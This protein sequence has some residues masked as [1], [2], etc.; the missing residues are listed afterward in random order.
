MTRHENRPR[1]PTGRTIAERKTARPT[2]PASDDL[3]AEA[4]QTEAGTGA[5][6]GQTGRQRIAK[7]MARVGLCSRRDAEAWIVDGRVT[8]NG[9]IL[10]SP[11]QDV[12]PSD[13]I[14][15][16]GMP[17]PDA[18]KT[19]L[20][21]F[22]K[23][24]GLV[25]SDHD[26]E[27]RQT[28]TDYLR[29]TWP[30]GPRVVTVGR[31]DIN[32]EGLLLLTN[33][34]GLARVLELPSTGWIRRYRVRA[35]GETDQA[36]LDRLHDGVTIEGIDYA[37]I[38]AKLDRTQGANSWLTMGLR[39]GKN[40]EIKRVLE[41]IGLE[42]NRLIRLS[43]G[44]F[45]LLD[46]PEGKV[47]EV[48]TRV[49]RD[50]L[51]ASLAAAGG[52]DLPEEPAA[53]PAFRAETRIVSRANRPG[54]K[55]ARPDAKRGKTAAPSAGRVRDDD[56]RPTRHATGAP[57][58]REEP[59]RRERPV[60]GTRKHVS[61]LRAEERDDLRKGPRK[62]IERTDTKDRKDRTVTVE[63]L[64]TA[65]PEAPP[66]RGAARTTS[67][68]AAPD[69]RLERPVRDHSKP[70]FAREASQDRDRAP[71][72][73]RASPSA[74][75]KRVRVARS[76]GSDAADIRAARPHQTRP[77]HQARGERVVA[78]GPTGGKARS[79]RPRPEANAAEA[80]RRS[81][82]ERTHQAP[83]DKSRGDSSDRVRADR[84][85]ARSKDK[86][87]PF[88]GPSQASG[89][90]GDA[91][92]RP[93]KPRDATARAEKPRGEKTRNVGGERRVGERNA[94][95]RDARKSGGQRGASG[96]AGEKPRDPTRPPRGPAK[97]PRTA[98]PRP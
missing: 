40:R 17:L 14:L 11:A 29:E 50:Q 54:T 96:R 51:G 25:T 84:L 24:R 10:T 28:V 81:R 93:S 68:D 19:R 34:G 4:G 5:T 33:D 74:Q 98:K 78:R 92:P 26:P 88:A 32:T 57:T 41:H 13:E 82:D 85:S 64:V 69:R 44:P 21:L 73:D 15:V 71:P 66:R 79:V 61:F 77:E 72:R 89:R 49:L 76:G 27:G 45:Q 22:H 62:R 43:F 39:E 56:R 37:G 18:E 86:R 36:V 53:E 87:G 12:G 23:P 75:A 6:D 67:R 63:R 97:G 95:E 1:K 60:A 58:P 48:R 91:A 80:P 7:L 65:R 30:E 20:F 47:E 94:K 70:R 31:L 55:G 38:E 35:K 8:L 9:E 42:V 3:L 46:L 59:A 83:R 90:R 52:V 16:D 2:G